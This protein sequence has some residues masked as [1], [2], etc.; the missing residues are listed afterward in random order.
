MTDASAPRVMT[1]DCVFPAMALDLQKVDKTIRSD[2]K[3]G[4]PNIKVRMSSKF[5]ATVIDWAKWSIV[6]WWTQQKRYPL[7]RH[8]VTNHLRMALSWI[9]G[10]DLYEKHTTPMLLQVAHSL[11][12]EPDN[13]R[14]IVYR[15]TQLTHKYGSKPWV[16]RDTVLCSLIHIAN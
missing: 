7:E 14:Q 5:Y 12:K 8:H 2:S 13:A 1:K 9:L 16:L 10:R 4:F 11:C 15:V 6:E 3:I